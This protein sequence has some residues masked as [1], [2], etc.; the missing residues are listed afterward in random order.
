ML[1]KDIQNAIHDLYALNDVA[2]ENVWI[3][4]FP[5]DEVILMPILT[6]YKD[7]IEE[8][9]VAQTDSDD[10]LCPYVIVRALAEDGCVLFVFTL[11]IELDKL[12]QAVL[13]MANEKELK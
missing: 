13:D 1:S 3:Y 8:V 5:L 12:K 2:P 6:E 11:G 9:I 7:S 10:E 4:V